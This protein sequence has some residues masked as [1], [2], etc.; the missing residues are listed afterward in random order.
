[1]EELNGDAALASAAAACA[2]ANDLPPSARRLADAF[3]A[4]FSR[5]AGVFRCEEP[6]S[7]RPSS[8]CSRRT[9]T[10]APWTRVPCVDATRR[11]GRRRRRG[12]GLRLRVRRQCRPL[13]DGRGRLRLPGRLRMT[14][15]LERFNLRPP[16]GGADLRRARRCGVGAPGHRDRPLS[17]RGFVDRRR[18]GRQ[19]VRR[20]RSR[21]AKRRAAFE[22][23]RGRGV[24]GFGAARALDKLAAAHRLR[25]RQSIDDGDVVT[26]ICVAPPGFTVDEVP[27]GA[28]E[29][30]A[31]GVRKL[32]IRSDAVA[33]TIYLD[34]EPRPGKPTGCAHY[35][36]LR[37]RRRRERHR[38]AGGDVGTSLSPHGCRP[39]GAIVSSSYGRRARPWRQW[40]HALHGAIHRSTSPAP[41]RHARV[42]GR[43][44][45]AGD[46]ARS[47]GAPAPAQH[48]RHGGRR[49]APCRGRVR[50]RTPRRL[51]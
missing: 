48:A 20:R 3:H 34:L 50:S 9:S 36:G 10:R 40:G 11:R 12:A 43:G 13:F 25:E 27:C 37:V 22:E 41:G 2:A 39:S 17:S 32:Q 49:G 24:A 38:R 8:F 16:R 45:T 31:P 44:G 15:R 1:M 42:H 5:D 30:W 19:G 29:A 26:T 18:R 23:R 28:D 33:A 47:A 14:L 6:W 35:R 7:A 46:G 4:E 51:R 21:R